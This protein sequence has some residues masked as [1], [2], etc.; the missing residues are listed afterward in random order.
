M[1][2]NPRFLSIA[3]FPIG[4]FL[5]AGA[6][7]GCGGGG[8]ADPC[9]PNPCAGLHKTICI[10]QGDQPLCL[11]DPG[12]VQNQSG[13]CVP[14]DI[15]PCQPNPC[16]APHRT[17]CRNVSGSAQ[18]DCDPG[19]VLE[20]D[21]CVLADPCHPNP[22]QEP[23]RSVC[24][25]VNGQA[26]CGCDPDYL[27]SEGHC[28]RPCQVQP[29]PC[30]PPKGLCANRGTDFVCLCSPGYLESGNGDCVSD[31]CEPNPCSG[32]RRTACIRNGASFLCRCDPG[33]RDEGGTCVR[34]RKTAC[35]L[36]GWCFE[37]PRPRTE[38]FLGVWQPDA[39]N[40]LICGGA[41]TLLHYDGTD[42]V[43]IPLATEQELRRIHGTSLSDVFVTG[44]GGLVLHFDGVS[45][46][47]LPHG[48]FADLNGVFAAAPGKAWVTGARGTLQLFD[49]EAWQ[50][51][52]D[53][54][55]TLDSWWDVWAESPVDVHAV[56]DFG[57][58]MD[59]DGERWVRNHIGQDVHLSAVRG[60][61]GGFRAVVS[62]NGDVFSW[63]GGGWST[64]NS[65]LGFLISSL[66]LDSP[67]EMVVVGYNLMS[68]KGL[69]VRMRRGEWSAI[70]EFPNKMA[71]GVGGPAD[72][73]IVVGANGLLRRYD[74]SEFRDVITGPRVRLRSVWTDGGARIIACGGGGT[75]LRRTAG[76]WTE[77]HHGTL[78]LSAVFGLPT[79]CAWLVGAQGRL[80]RDCGAG[81]QSVSL[82]GDVKGDLLAGYV[83]AEDDVFVAGDKVILRGSAAGFSKMTIPTEAR[84]TSI[85]GSSASDVWAT[86]E[87]TPPPLLHFDGNVWSLANAPALQFSELV[88][89]WGSAAN[90]VYAVGE[91][92]A[93][94]HFD[95]SG[96]SLVSTSATEDLVGISGDSAGEVM[97]AGLSGTILKKNGAFF[98]RMYSG[99][100]VHLY[101]IGLH[102]AEGWFAVGEDGAILRKAR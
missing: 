55:N 9:V 87:G 2:K 32:E 24:S 83:A 86:G 62:A 95:G 56:G 64:M 12:Y 73:P 65:M 76:G 63:D 72:H 48:P 30:Q 51:P 78:N 1:W 37:N 47:A 68:S 89:L 35:S 93:I 96:W 41:G 38:N 94:A 79:G 34:D 23:N 80:M 40:A 49:G 44:S 50:A 100:S 85:W 57:G 45:W 60:L 20:G 74:G 15:D 97:I 99:T 102:A 98:S 54:G 58:L 70:G 11:C 7:V 19:Y 28:V 88:A 43:P 82:P 101:S 16:Q 17:Q 52:V 18:C 31:P 13:D 46:E 22:C 14:D 36:D 25:V 53:T 6:P 3:A 67:D 21:F 66:A 8:N 59:F 92:G 84:F 61:P 90:D 42:L 10:S 77:E 81:F 71:Y 29:A 75:V 91:D 33:Y 27:F 26:S 39:N 4:C 5:V 69:V